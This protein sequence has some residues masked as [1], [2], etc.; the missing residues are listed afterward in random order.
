MSIFRAVIFPLVLY[1]HGNW[2]LTLREERRLRVLANNR[3]LRILFGPNR[4]R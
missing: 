1:G 4:S 2:S 3:V